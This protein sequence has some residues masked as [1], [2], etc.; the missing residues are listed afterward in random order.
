MTISD[1]AVYS[2][3][4]QNAAEAERLTAMATLNTSSAPEVEVEDNR[5]GNEMN[6]DTSDHQLNVAGGKDT[7]V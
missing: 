4:Y 5:E 7:N 6:F 1:S 2:Q 3:Y